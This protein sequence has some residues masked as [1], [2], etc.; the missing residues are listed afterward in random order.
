MR[1]HR[2][3]LAA[4]RE[5][6][7]SQCVRVWGLLLLLGRLALLCGLCRFAC[8]GC[9][10]VVAGLRGLFTRIRDE[11]KRQGRTRRAAPW[12]GAGGGG[13]RT[14][15]ESQPKQCRVRARNEG[16]HGHSV[17]CRAHVRGTRT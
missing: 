5:R 11:K 13:A 17:R 14:W 8:P 2:Q 15:L 3:Q 10:S 9:A 12:G 4:K 16:R 6:L 1:R 7:P